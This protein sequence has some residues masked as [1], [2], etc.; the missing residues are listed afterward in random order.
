MARSTLPAPQDR[1]QPSAA[2]STE[3]ILAAV[4]GIVIVVAATADRT[5]PI[6]AQSPGVAHS[7]AFTPAG[8]FGGGFGAV[9]ADGTHAFAVRGDAIEAYD[10][11]DPA[12]P[13]LLGVS[14]PIDGLA[15]LSA[16]DGRVAAIGAPA[17][18][19]AG[20]VLTLLDEDSGTGA[21]S[22]A[23]TVDLAPCHAAAVQI[24]RAVVA[25]ACGVD[26][27]RLV[28]ARGAGRPSVAPLESAGSVDAVAFDGAQLLVGTTVGVRGDKGELALYD[29]TDPGRSAL[30]S[31][32]QWPGAVA[33]VGLAGK[34]AVVGDRQEG[35][36]VV[37]AAVV[38]VDEVARWSATAERKFESY[39]LPVI[40]TSGT[41][42]QMAL[43][44][45][46]RGGS[47][48]LDVDTTRP[49]DP[50]V[51][52]LNFLW[53]TRAVAPLPHGALVSDVHRGL[54]TYG[55]GGD[56]ALL[57]RAHVA[58]LSHAFG[59]AFDGSRLLVADDDDELWVLDAA[60]PASVHAVNWVSLYPVGYR[61]RW[62][63]TYG[64]GIA[65]DGRL[66]YVTRGLSFYNMSGGVA[67]LDIQDAVAPLTVGAW[68]IDFE[69]GPVMPPED[70]IGLLSITRNDDPVIV[71]GG[72]LSTGFSGTTNLDAT[73]PSSPRFRRLFR[74]WRSCNRYRANEI[75]YCDSYGLAADGQTA[76]VAQGVAGVRV[77][78][79]APDAPTS[80]LR[81]FEGP[82]G[83]RDVALVGDA[84]LVAYDLWGGGT[85]LRVIDRRTGEAVRSFEGF[86]AR[87]VDVFGDTAY[88]VATLPNGG[89]PVL[90]A[91]DLTDPFAPVERGRLAL[92]GRIDVRQRAPSVV[93]RGDLLAVVSD[94]AGVE[95]FR[96]TDGDALAAV[97]PGPTITAWPTWAPPDPRTPSPTSEVQP[98]PT[99][100][101]E[102]EATV[103]PPP[104][105]DH[106]LLFVPIAVSR[107]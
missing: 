34:Y 107:P 88:V 21:P 36:G 51:G 91:Y 98:L 59:A 62:L 82:E 87:H 3:S 96:L 29:A 69:S 70:T 16:A 72:L 103:A 52:D 100:T 95:L 104:D 20:A 40:S 26:G 25:V 65:L 17:D 75:G 81:T 66:A 92:D 63:P 43:P 60:N 94:V 64:G 41:S 74:D 7:L 99:M 9:A 53:G 14:E 55:R 6:A 105:D 102:A 101:S 78:D 39:G 58:S 1:G 54:V 5:A 79:L 44:V 8:H 76:Y 10:V 57:E 28:D 18:D 46:I 24:A 45:W 35:G 68:S 67:V 47:I 48:L 80:A 13:R 15:L 4:V 73:D 86:S 85:G 97:D 89:G 30:I 90:I 23:A 93:V 49:N 83:A 12:A 106:R 77:Y 11:A 50:W 33:A 32:T 38:H 31:T 71:P 84:L 22:V 19:P 27:V 61:Y 2:P 37:H 56:G 42:A